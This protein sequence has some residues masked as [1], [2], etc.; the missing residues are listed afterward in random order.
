MCDK[1][2]IIMNEWN[3]KKAVQCRKCSTCLQARKRAWIGRINAEIQTANETWFT[4][5][6]Y[7]GGLDN[8]KAYWLHYS[9][10]QKTFKR[11][12]KAGYKFKYLAVGEHGK[13]QNRAHFHALIFWE[14][15]P[16]NVPMGVQ[17]NKIDTPQDD[18]E[19]P[20]W[21]HGIC[22]ME[23][24]RSKQGCASYVM[25]YLDKNALSKGLLKNSNGLG[26][27][28]LLE[29]ARERARAGVGLFLD[30][31]TFTIPGNN[32]TNGD[33]FYYV[34]EREGAPYLKMMLAYLDEWVACR[35]NQFP[36]STDDFDQWFEDVTQNPDKL[37]RH[38]QTWLA[39]TLDIGASPVPKLPA[40]LWSL[41]QGCYIRTGQGPAELV[42]YKG[43]LEIW[44]LDL[45]VSPGAT[46]DPQRAALRSQHLA[47]ARK[48]LQTCQL[49]MALDSIHV[50]SLL[51]T[52]DGMLSSERHPLLRPGNQDEAWETARQTLQN[53]TIPETSITETSRTGST[54]PSI[55]RDLSKN[56][57][58]NGVK[59]TF[60]SWE[61][62]TNAPTP[63]RPGKRPR[64]NAATH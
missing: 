57:R 6:T 50:P 22:Q 1:P 8:T 52:L 21:P 42:F 59:P 51:E 62:V 19:F 14:T 32:A 29:F 16:P 31:P 9:D 24:P 2:V 49:P 55:T 35:P 13:A 56:P 26:V 41:G 18:W 12:R 20:W 25:D 28:Y 58:G 17:L 46:L 48:V 60:L 15:T 64:L 4:T 11:L 63:K 27:Q 5:F 30:G 45:H 40:S 54:T 37:P 36:P 47:N 10:L 34:L 39:K 23:I 44:Q 33:A 3:E 61:S 43:D 53:P 7:G 38:I